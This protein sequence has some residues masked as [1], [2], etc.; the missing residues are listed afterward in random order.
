MKKILVIEDNTEIRENLAEILELSEY[1]TFTAENGK[2]GVE[3]A[4]E[5]IP[6]LIICD[7]MMP[8]LDGFG[9]LHILGKKSATS[10]I[11][12]IFL[13]A[14]TEKEDFRKG[15]NLGADDYITKPFDNV[16]LL[17]AVKMRLEKSERLKKVFDGTPSG[18]SAFINEAKGQKDLEK[19][20]EE[21]EVRRLPRKSFIYQEGDTPQRLY[22]VASGKVKTY[23][24]ND[25]GKEYIT[26]VYN[27]GSFLGYNALIQ[28][29]A[30]TETAMV[31]DEAE[32]SFIP[33]EDFESMLNHNRDF[34]AQFIKM[35]AN[36]VDEKEEQLL[37]LAYNSI[38]KRVAESLVKLHR[39]Y[40]KDDKE[41]IS[42]LREDLA[43]IVGTAKESVIRTLTDFKNE[44]LIA[45]EHGAI[46]ILDVDKL[47]DLPG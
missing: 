42:I 26:D 37:S 13:T 14:K 25:F 9:V 45:V 17:D 28:K 38:R 3:K 40:Q 41:V 29:R 46:R 2:V 43:G 7:V 47:D 15:M 22:F 18:L 11:P 19:L 44:G 35:L 20:S 12:F 8:E 33:K 16:E 6:D 1:Q 32:I 27:S 30:Y 39:Q 4:L 23:R 31:I 10:D 5:E 24:T 21:R 36:N 34:T